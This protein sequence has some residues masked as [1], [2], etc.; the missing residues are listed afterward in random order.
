M[1]YSYPLKLSSGL[2]ANPGT[3]VFSENPLKLIGHISR[4]SSRTIIHFKNGST[5][6]DEE[7]YPHQL[8]EKQ[9]EDIT[10][11][12][13]V[14]AG[15]HLSILK[16]DLIKSFFIMTEAFQNFVIRAGKHPA[17]S[18]SISARALGCYL[19]GSDPPVKI[20]LV[21]DPR[22]KNVTLEG[23]WVKTFRPDGFARALEKPKKAALKRNVTRPMSGDIHWTIVNEP[24][25]R[26][27][28]GTENGLACLITVK[29]NQRV[30]AELRMQGT[31][32]HLVIEPE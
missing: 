25:I 13:R 4:M 2:V 8:S 7:M 18:P 22:T 20:L 21:M 26:R 3:R 6:T 29:E 15:W 11:V 9:L 16:S 14:I 24:P 23:T 28:Y 10:S 17:P 31:N 30:K 19:E 27:V 12:E 32:C 1:N 5:L